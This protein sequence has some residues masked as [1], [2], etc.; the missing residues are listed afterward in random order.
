LTSVRWFALVAGLSLVTSLSGARTAGAGAATAPSVQQMVGQ[1]MLVRMQGWTPSAS[2][3]AR[4]RRGEIGGVVLY[5]DNFGAAGPAA[6]VG[7]LQG[8]AKSGHRPPLLIA[9]DQEGGIV[10]RLPGAPSLA[11][12]EMRTAAIAEAQG[13]ATAHNLESHRINVDLAPVLDVGRGGFITPRTF[14]TTPTTVAARGSAFAEGLARGHV[15]ATAKHFPGLGYASLS[16]DNAPTKVTA[17][18]SRLRA[19]WLP[20]RTAIKA[21]IPLV[22]MSTAVYPALGSIWP[23]ALSPNI[24]TDLRQLGF[25]GPIVTDALQTPAVNKLMTTGNAAVQAVIAGD[26]LVLAAG[27]TDDHADTDGAST[28]A[29]SA[30]VAA[31][32]SGRLSQRTLASAYTRVIAL[33]AAL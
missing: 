29:F 1:L 7:M 22:L 10:K 25:T 30:L 9:V 28:A 15:L 31:A 5:A 19:D 33:K 11:P 2:F 6:L 32:R 27:S 18:A 26:D 17:T 24:V 13:L 14:G 23:A 3:L 16:T 21:G 20:F 12:P 4:V 8:A